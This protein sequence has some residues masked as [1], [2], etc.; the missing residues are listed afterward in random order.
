MLLLLLSVGL[1]TSEALVELVHLQD[2]QPLIILWS[3]IIYDAENRYILAL[4][5]SVLATWL[6]HMFLAA[7]VM[8]RLC[9]SFFFIFEFTAILLHLIWPGHPLLCLHAQ[10]FCKLSKVHKAIYYWRVH[11]VTNEALCTGLHPGSKGFQFLLDAFT[12]YSYVTYIEKEL[13]QC[14]GLIGSWDGWNTIG[15]MLSDTHTWGDR[16]AWCK[17]RHFIWLYAHHI[18]NMTR[19]TSFHI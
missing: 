10:N 16:I 15:L 3:T 6:S 14:F 9:P 13:T 8:V 7:H 18:R 5:H 1:W 12:L 11:S 2:R 19:W 17:K 4:G